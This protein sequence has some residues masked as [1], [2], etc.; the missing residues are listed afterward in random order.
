MKKK[1]ICIIIIVVAILVVGIRV[2]T[3]VVE[4]NNRVENNIS[5]EGSGEKSGENLE[6][7]GEDPENIDEITLNIFN[8]SGDVIYNKKIMTDEKY[9]FD[10]LLENKEEINMVYEEDKYGAYIVSLMGI[11]QGD[12]Y[13]WSYSINNEYAPTSVSTCELTDDAI[14]DFKIEQFNFWGEA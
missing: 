7:F 9:L 11:E 10:V 14:Y 4:N 12:N 13:Y 3:S 2:G 6:F 5:G 8:K 1:I